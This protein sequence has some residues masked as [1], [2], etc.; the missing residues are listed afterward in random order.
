M[1]YQWR[2]DGGE[3]SPWSIREDQTLVALPPGGHRFEVRSRD[4]DGFVDQSTAAHL[5][6]V[7]APWWRNAWV[8]GLTAGLLGLVVLQSARVLQRDRRIRAELEGEL[9]TARELQTSLMPTTSPE[10]PGLAVAGRCEMASQVGGDFYQY[11]RRG[12]RLAVSLADVTGHAMEAAFPAAVFSGLLA[13]QMEHM[14]SLPALIRELNELLCRILGRH[15]FVCFTLADMDCQTGEVSLVNCGCPGALHYEAR[16]GQIGEWIAPTHP[17]GI[18]ASIDA[19]T[20]E[21]RLRPGDWLV[22]HSDGF[23]EAV[24]GTGRPF[25]YDR[26]RETIRQACAEGLGPWQ[27]IERLLDEVRAFS[28]DSTQEDDMTCVAVKVG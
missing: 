22:L 2:I 14:N 13:G 24:D 17:L 5:F 8:I 15:T 3:W 11:F 7:E 20:V 27:L 25:G 10:L 18:R 4:A 21:G 19:Q 23:P 12:D 9:D 16:T 26:T 6:E 1:F 28:G